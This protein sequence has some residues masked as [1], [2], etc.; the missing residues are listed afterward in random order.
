MITVDEREGT[1]P[2]NVLT[3]DWLP[4]RAFD[5]CFFADPTPFFPTITMEV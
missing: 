4:E 5:D 2:E 1:G 3:L